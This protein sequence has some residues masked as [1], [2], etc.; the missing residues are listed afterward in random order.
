M[1][2]RSIAV[3][4]ML[5]AL[6]VSAS[7]AT[8]PDVQL[9]LGLA[10]FRAGD[11]TSS[12]LDLGQAAQGLLTS[13]E[14]QAYIDTGRSDRFQ[15]LETALVYLALSQFR[16]AQEDD[17]RDT[18]LRLLEIEKLAPTYAN[19]PLQTDA[20]EFETLVA[21]LIPTANLPKNAQLAAVD[22]TRP[23]PSVTP[24]AEELPPPP[25]TTDTQLIARQAA[26][27]TYL[28]FESERMEREAMKNRLATGPAP[29]QAAPVQIAQATPP[30][31][32][33]EAPIVS[34]PPQPETLQRQDPSGG[35][36]ILP[37]TPEPAPVQ[38][39][40]PREEPAL[41][42]TRIEP[43]PTVEPP[44]VSLPPELEPEPTQPVPTPAPAQ[45][46]IPEADSATIRGYL[47][48]LRQAEAFGDNGLVPEAEAIYTRLIN[49]PSAPREVI[50][51]AAVGLY[52]TGSFHESVEAFRRLG[53][54]ARGEEDL[55]YYHAVS[56]YEIGEY[57]AAQK[58]LACALPFI[59]LTDEVARYR[60][61]IEQMLRVAQSV[62]QQALSR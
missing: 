41:A 30:P 37:V 51:A 16:Q 36:A 47:T 34:V 11:Y 39:A 21:A 45:R 32:P 26:V 10:A 60:L 58:E 17:A 2:R 27:N 31:E 14:L 35:Q 23:L 50:A 4:A 1:V 52:R 5:T 8:T 6:A 19:L 33:R 59:E 40:E 7:A 13:E 12:I 44:I 29:V 48:E 9:D 55:R 61:R 3:L 25:Q 62:Q 24:V 57:A 20:A 53:V 18:I 38:A 49:T 28:A 46:P 56:L 43:Q 42:E 15:P 54:F 22:P